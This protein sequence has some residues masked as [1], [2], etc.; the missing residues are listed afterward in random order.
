MNDR[1]LYINKLAQG[2]AS[3]EDGMKWFEASDDVQKQDIMRSL[4]MCIF[5][6]HPTTE[7]IVQGIKFSKLKETYSPCVLVKE[8]PLNEARQKV[9]GM[10]GLDQERAFKLFVAIFS[11]ADKRRRDSE[12]NGGCSHEWHNNEGL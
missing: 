7:D 1:E 5:Q 8:K 3:I 12:C 10:R 4:D 2:F 9:L 6:S 11:N